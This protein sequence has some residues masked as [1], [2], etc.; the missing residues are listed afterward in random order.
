MVSF[1]IY[2]ICIIASWKVYEKM[3]RPGWNC[4]IPI[5]NMYVF[6]D[7]LYGNGWKFL[8]LL[9]PF[10]NIYVIIKFYIDLSHAFGESGGFAAGLILL[11]PIFMAILGFGQYQFNGSPY[12]A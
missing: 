10:Y 1:I 3:G 12:T 5:Y 11:N 7:V 9:I 2:I 4:L 6:F 8:L